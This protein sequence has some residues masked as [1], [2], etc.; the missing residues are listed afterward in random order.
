MMQQQLLQQYNMNLS[1]GTDKFDNYLSLMYERNAEATIK[2]GYER[3]MM[4]YNT[5]Y[6][7]AKNVRISQ[8]CE[9]FSVDSIPFAN[10]YL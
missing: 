2:R 7:T 10:T 1:G 9:I 3:F 6:N 8:T 4:N 5:A